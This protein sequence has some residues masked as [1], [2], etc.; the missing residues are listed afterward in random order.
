MG[1]T[2]I[3]SSVSSKGRRNVDYVILLSTQ[4]VNPEVD[5]TVYAI[6]GCRVYVNLP[7][8]EF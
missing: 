5:G 8:P 2:C 7:V 3:V 6:M 4:Y 1:G